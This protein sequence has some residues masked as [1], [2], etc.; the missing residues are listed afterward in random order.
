MLPLIL[1]L[2]SQYEMV[3]KDLSDSGTPGTSEARKTNP[4]MEAD[5]KSVPPPK[6]GRGR[7]R[8]SES[9]TPGVPSGATPQKPVQGPTPK[10]SDTKPKRIRKRKGESAAPA[11]VDVA[12]VGQPVTGVLDGSFDAGYLLSVRVGNTNTVLRGVV[13]GPGLSLPISK[14]NDVAP[15]V[16]HIKRDET[17][18]PPQVPAFAAPAA[19]SV[20][21]MGPVVTVPAA[22]IV[23]ETV[24]S[25]SAVPPAVQLS[26]DGRLLP[27]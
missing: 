4:E 11:I 8:K 20:V 12:L 23:P 17:I 5:A 27:K 18:P 14:M 25:A 24:P 15:T 13:F 6:R 1:L 21:P 2:R 16:R 10:K 26:P 22:V 3:A 7:P 19:P 9:A